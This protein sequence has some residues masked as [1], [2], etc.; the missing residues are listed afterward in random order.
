MCLSKF[1]LIALSLLFG[2]FYADVFATDL[3]KELTDCDAALRPAPNR[4]NVTLPND[5]TTVVVDCEQ[6]GALKD[7]TLY[8]WQ[9]ADGANPPLD[10][11]SWRIVG[12]AYEKVEDSTPTDQGWFELQT[13]GEWVKFGVSCGGGFDPSHPKRQF[14]IVATLHDIR[15]VDSNRLL[16]I[17]RI[18]S[19]SVL[20]PGAP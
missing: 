12:A 17:G 16:A 7:G 4:V 8:W 15:P 10:R 9:F 18:C 14:R 6:D 3:L 11:N 20:H 1:P 19:A 5:G 13:N 2:A